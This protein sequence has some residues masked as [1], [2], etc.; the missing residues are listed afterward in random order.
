MAKICFVFEQPKNSSCCL[1]RGKFPNL[2]YQP[3]DDVLLPEYLKKE[4]KMIEEKA[5][6]IKSKPPKKRKN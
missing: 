2:S 3:S 1:D 5:L 6:K 4:I